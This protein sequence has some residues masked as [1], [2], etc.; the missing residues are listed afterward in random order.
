MNI[1][2]FILFNFYPKIPKQMVRATRGT[3]IKTEPSIREIIKHLHESDNFI[4]EEL[5]DNALFIQPFK[6]DDIR[7]KVDTILN[8]TIK[9]QN[10]KEF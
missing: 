5:N 7:K 9:V 8:N 1:N 6:I 2:H 4:I 10:D 3:Y